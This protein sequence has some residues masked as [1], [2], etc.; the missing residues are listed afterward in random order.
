MNLS[1]D[2]EHRIRSASACVAGAVVK[3]RLVNCDGSESK[4]P[5]VYLEL[6]PVLGDHLSTFHARNEV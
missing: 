4:R 3:E 2:S 1:V 5:S 6:M